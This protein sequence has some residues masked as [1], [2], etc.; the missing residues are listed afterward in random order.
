M[1]STGGALTSK[2]VTKRT[3]QAKSEKAAEEAVVDED[4][5]VVDPEESEVVAPPAPTWTPPAITDIRHEQQEVVQSARGRSRPKPRSAVC[6]RL[7]QP[8]TCAPSTSSRTRTSMPDQPADTVLQRTASAVESATFE[9]LSF[10]ATV[11][12]PAVAMMAAPEVPPAPPTLPRVLSNMLSAFVSVIDA[13][14]PGV[15]V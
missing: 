9:A 4:A 3:E 6:R 13:N 14:I 10:S 8:L 11:Q 7:S 5:E 2:K 12:E 15:P 1:L